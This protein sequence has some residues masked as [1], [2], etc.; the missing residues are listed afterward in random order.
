MKYGVVNTDVDI[1][2]VWCA[3]ETKVNTYLSNIR[4]TLSVFRI[5]LIIM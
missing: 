2:F 1:M 4:N 5:F 3:I